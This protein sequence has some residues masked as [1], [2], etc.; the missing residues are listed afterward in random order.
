[1]KE[2]LR[3]IAVDGHA[4]EPVL[5]EATG[6]DPKLVQI[7]GRL[8]YRTSYGQNVLQHS[9]EVA[10]LSTLL[11]EQLGANVS[12]AKKGGLLHDIG[13]AVDH[14]IEGTHIEIGKNILKNTEKNKMVINLAHG[15]KIIIILT[16]V[17]GSNRW[18]IWARVM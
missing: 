1:M 12:I 4:E 17:E 6:L 7:L 10:H 13:K 15:I 9:L 16:R 18:G 5:F 8:K 11:A 3:F 2:G 14:E